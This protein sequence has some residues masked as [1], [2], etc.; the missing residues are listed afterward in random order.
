MGRTTLLLLIVFFAVFAHAK[1]LPPD[2]VPGP[3]K[4]WVDWV[5]QDQTELGCPFIYNS[6]EQKRCSWPSQLGLDFT[7]TKGM[8]AISWSVYREGW[9]TLPGDQKHWPQNVTA[10]GKAATVLDRNGVPSMKLAAGT[11]HIKGDFFWDAIPE[12]LGIPAESG[13]VGLSINGA[14]ITMPSIRD[15]RL[16]LTENDIGQKKPENVQNSLD[17]QVF[18]KLTDDVPMQ[19]TTH[20]VLEV[21][22]EQREVKLAKPVLNDFIPLSLQSPLPARI[23]ADGQLLIQVRPGRWQMDIEARS[24]KETNAIALAASNPDWPSSEIW[25]FDA[26]PDLRVVEVEQLLPID[27]S[28]TNAPEEWRHLPTYKINQ[29]EGMG[30][31]VIRRGDPEPEPNQLSLNRKLWLD[32]DGAGYTINDTISGKMTKGWRLDA[33]PEMQLGKVS[34]D[35]K[36]QLITLT[37]SGKQGVEVRKGAIA[38]DADSRSVGNIKS[39]SAVGWAQNFNQVNAEL[40]LPPGWRLLAASGVDNVP[41]T[42]IARWTLL[43]L[44]LVLIAAL[45]TSRLFG[46]LWGAFA[47][48]TLVLIWHEVGSP[49]Y[50]WLNIL[51]ATALLKVLPQGKFLTAITW[52]R[53]AFWLALVLIVVPFMVNQVRT[54]LYPQLEYPWQNIAYPASAPSPAPPIAMNQATS[55]M[56][57]VAPAT[58]P[59]QEQEMAKSIMPERKRK[60]ASG[61]LASPSYKLS[62]D[63][64]RYDPDAKVQTG[65]GLP[66]WQWHKVHLSWNGSVDAGQAL[67]LWYL[68]P[69]LVMLLNFIR[70]ALVTVLALLMFGL[71]GKLKFKLKTASPALLWLLVLPLLATPTQKAYAD[72]PTQETLDELKNRLL[73]APDCLPNCAQIPQMNV[74]IN[75]KAVE[76]ILQI[77]SQQAVN[78]PLPAAYEQWFPNQV[79][80]DGKTATGLY[81]NANSLWLYVPEGEHQLVLRGAAPLLATFTLP[82]PLRPN[83]VTVETAQS[84]WQVS[85]LQDNGQ[86]DDQLQFNRTSKA[87]NNAQSTNLTPVLL[88]PFVRVERTL[89]LGLD[90]RVITQVIRQ[91]PADSAVVLELPLLAGELVTTPGIHVKNA[92]VEVN[93]PAQQTVMQ[94]EST[95]EKSEKIT[96]AAAQTNQWIEVWKADVSPI[97][98]IESSGITVIHNNNEGQWLPEWHPWPGETVALQI[99]RPKTLEGQTLTIDSSQLSIKP[100]KRSLDADLTISIRSSQGSQH[101][102]TL[103]EQAALQSVAINGQTLPLR[104]EGRK[105]TLP[106]NPGKQD[107]TLSWQEQSEISSVTK[108]P[109]LD[110]GQASVNTRLNISLGQDCWVLFVWGPKLGPAVLFWG[111]LVVI[112]IL[113]IGLGKVPLTPLKS[114]HWFLLLLGLS[115]VPMESACLVVAWLMVLGWR[116][117]R[118]N[119]NFKYF[120]LLQVII[121]LFTVFSLA[122]L[123]FAVEQ[124][125]LGGSPNM[126]IT[127]NQSSA[128]DLNWY[129]DRSSA[130]LPQATV[131]SVPLMAYRLL[132]LVWSFWLASSLLNWLKWGWNCFATNG[133]WNKKAEKGQ[134][135]PV[136]PELK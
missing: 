130:T 19:V 17:I 22:G 84:G 24:I 132:M 51:A 95:L 2:Q 15:G 121:G 92:K 50:V 100:G 116:G 59:M 38:L 128:F 123:V 25:V 115:Q 7:A 125:L 49:Q 77:H 131:V 12:S 104:Q 67:R 118:P 14:T 65:P 106:I 134:G 112:V 41:D 44:F 120:N 110:L 97:W 71:A 20:L 76:I 119:N 135:K 82:L 63:F 90:W 16:W 85:G 83:R 60:Y 78:V 103:P 45:A 107:V 99:T 136:V 94:W 13:L 129:Q 86:V 10:D 73:E 5:L 52:Y 111:V 133:L 23:E 1:P 55:A 53:N 109:Q 56:D 126:Q 40:N 74:A 33:L 39:I 34:L 91:S 81:R 48:L 8:F 28:Q 35:G 114:W 102:L 32:F 70:V 18:R 6:Y 21:S 98:H 26:R 3:L 80:V 113:A 96:F 43:D 79:T 54:G 101:T 127:G 89:Q 36:S 72:F 124:G 31:K 66:Q 64:S 47:L 27:A 29:G 4:P 61:G 58:E 87:A 30:L 93:M 57:A 62:A 69:T 105:L 122:I 42:W 117:L 88:P 68:S 37:G 108:T 9:V 46:R 75:E 11:Y